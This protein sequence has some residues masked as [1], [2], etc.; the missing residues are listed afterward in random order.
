[1]SCELPYGCWEL[2]LGPLEEQPVL[3]TAEP[4]HQPH[5]SVFSFVYGFACESVCVR[6]VH[7]E[8]RGFHHLWSWTVH[9]GCSHSGPLQEQ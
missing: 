7:T 1:V 8:P 9:H 5:I 4:S 6:P 2:N 3:L